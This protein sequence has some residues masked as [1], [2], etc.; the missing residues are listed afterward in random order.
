MFAFQIYCDFSGYSD[1]ARGLAAWMGYDFGLNFNHPY[2]SRSLREFWTRWHI[3]LSTWFRDYV[4]IP[5]GGSRKGEIKTYVNLWITMLLSAFWHG[6][7][8]HFI[9]WGFVHAFF[10][11]IEKITAW[12]GKIKKFPAGNGLAW[13]LVSIQVLFAW[14]FFRSENIAQSW[15]IVTTILNY[16][17]WN[18]G[19]VFQFPKI[20]YIV[21]ITIVLRELYFLTGLNKKISCAP[22]LSLVVHEVKLIVLIV[23]IIFL[24][25]PSSTFIYFQF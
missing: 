10:L 11:T 6:A 24:Q 4:Y 20:T 3:S 25:G 19:P 8:W 2:I 14:I 7:A 13:V 9:A 21:L 17:N 18:W 23:A 5:L 22:Q 1:I 15:D 12:P 16:K